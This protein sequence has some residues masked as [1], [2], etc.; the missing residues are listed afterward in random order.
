MHSN[1][2]YG[3]VVAKSTIWPGAMSFF[4][5]GMWGEIYVGN[6]HKH[7]DITYFPIQPPAIQDDP[8]EREDQPE[9][10]KKM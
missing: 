3:V 8:E 5:R 2:Q 6:G 4:W 1:L 10:S 7:E 9:V